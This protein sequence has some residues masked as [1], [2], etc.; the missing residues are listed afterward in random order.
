MKITRSKY[1]FYPFNHEHCELVKDNKAVLQVIYGSGNSH[2]CGYVALKKEQVPKEWWR[3]Y[4]ADALQYLN[5]HGGITYCQVLN[6]NEKIVKQANKNL[7]NKINNLRES[8]DL[9]S[10]SI[11]ESCKYFGQRIKLELNNNLEIAKHKNSYVVFGFDCNH[12]QDEDD[13][14]LK[15]LNYVMELVE[16][17]EIQLIAYSKVVHKWRKE[18]QE[19]Q[20]QMM[21]EVTALV[22]HKEEIGFGAMIDML[23]GA[24][25][26]NTKKDEDIKRQSYKKNGRPSRTAKAA[27]LLDTKEGTERRRKDLKEL[28]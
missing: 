9:L 21:D 17:M 16:D 6:N 18:S 2:L 25:S 24:K 4:D 14:R 26:F 1:N 28:K 23:C 20:A 3:N 8:T 22:K 12:Y 27:E 13:S 11:D 7:D 5:I 15:D 10:L 19:K